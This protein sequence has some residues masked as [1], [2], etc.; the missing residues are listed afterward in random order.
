[1]IRENLD[2]GR[3][4]FVQLVFG[5]RV[6]SRTPSR[7]RT[8]VLTTG[9]EPSLHFDYKHSRIKQ[10]C[11]LW[12]GPRQNASGYLLRVRQACVAYPFK[13]PNVFRSQDTPR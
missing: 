9:V 4:E 5:R 12:I 11:K 8:R 2:H 1:M 10:Y 3:P 6:N 7:F 13:A